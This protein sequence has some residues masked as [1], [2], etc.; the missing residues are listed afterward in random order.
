[1]R[2]DKNSRRRAHHG[3]FGPPSDFGPPFG[4]PGRGFGPP[5]FGPGGRG[6]RP[7]PRGRGFGRGPRGRRAGRG[8]VRAAI[9]LLLAEQPMHGYQI[10]QE[11]TERSSGA[12]TPSPGAVYPALGLLTD[13][14][15]V[16]TT[17]EG[18]RNLAS[19]TT[20][21]RAYVEAN[22]AEL[23]NP[24]ENLGHGHQ[25]RFELR[26]GV[27]AIIDATRQVGRVGTDAQVAAALSV[28]E[29]ARR[30][31]YLILAE[32]DPTPADDGAPGSRRADDAP[33]QEPPSAD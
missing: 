22:A 21:G 5:G 13:E 15:L 4:P 32:A 7:G 17:P 16:A 28:L 25:R 12:W 30:E 6:G 33:E 1:M 29:N 8:D 19:L 20:E 23:G 27:E 3:D 11:I 9:L 2:H 24:F 26:T 31:I 18:G 10:I 14:G